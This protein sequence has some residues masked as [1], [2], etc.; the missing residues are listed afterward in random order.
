MKMLV[1]AIVF[2]APRVHAPGPTVK[3]A[4]SLHTLIIFARHF[5]D[6]SRHHPKKVTAALALLN[7]GF[8][9][10]V[11]PLVPDASDLPAPRY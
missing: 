5:A 11:A 9:F 4:R 3:L 6:R 2:L 8:V 10:G 1:T 7:K